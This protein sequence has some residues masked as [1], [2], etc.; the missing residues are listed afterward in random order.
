MRSVSPED[1]EETH[2]EILEQLPGKLRVA[3]WTIEVLIIPNANSERL[4]VIMLD[5]NI[6]FIR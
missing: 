5:L 6:C 2:E 3:A 1:I 4:N